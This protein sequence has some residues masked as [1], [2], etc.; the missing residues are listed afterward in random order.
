MS[1]RAIFM[2]QYDPNRS[3]AQSDGRHPLSGELYRQLLGVLLGLQINMAGLG[4][5]H[6]HLSGELRR[7]L[8]GLG[9][10]GRKQLQRY[11]TKVMPVVRREVL[12]STNSVIDYAEESQ[13]RTPELSRFFTKLRQ[14]NKQAFS[15]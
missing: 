6:Y 9:K 15:I 13:P 4:D 5:F 8:E 7:T 1:T 2:D 3:L 14:Q 12:K 11:I 10:R